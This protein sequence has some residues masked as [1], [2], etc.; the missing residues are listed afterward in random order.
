MNSQLISYT[1]LPMGIAS[2]FPIILKRNRGE[3]AGYR[4]GGAGANTSSSRSRRHRQ[5][6]DHRHRHRFHVILSLRAVTLFIRSD[7]G[8]SEKVPGNRNYFLLLGEW[9]GMVDTCA[10]ISTCGK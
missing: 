2:F 1:S 7:A 6:A 5:P 3:G 10:R 4:P 8:M 9:R